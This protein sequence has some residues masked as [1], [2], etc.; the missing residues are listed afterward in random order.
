MWSQSI[1]LI[2]ILS[3]SKA[4]LFH[5]MYGDLSSTRVIGANIN[6]QSTV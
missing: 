5:R 4:N 3:N 1:L 6:G 2:E